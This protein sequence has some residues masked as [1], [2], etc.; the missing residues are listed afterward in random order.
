MILQAVPEGVDIDLIRK[1]IEK[2]EGVAKVH[3]LHIWTMD[4]HYN[5]MSLHA[6]VEG[7]RR[8]EIKTEI[9]E[10]LKTKYNIQHTTIE[11]E[12]NGEEC[13]QCDC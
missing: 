11:L 1:S 12:K 13:W 9:R 7:N 10:L 5:V 8:S 3:D 4:N 6:S 2:I